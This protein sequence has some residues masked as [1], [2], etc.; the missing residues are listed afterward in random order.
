MM[1]ARFRRTWIPSHIDGARRI[2]RAPSFSS[3]NGVGPNVIGSRTAGY[4][5]PPD[6]PS[7][8]L[9]CEIA[10]PAIRSIMAREE[11]MQSASILEKRN[12][13]E[14]EASDGRA[15]GNGSQRLRRG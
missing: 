15:E 14:F 5:A 10:S 6:A 13:S 3:A 11:R 1:I 4:A 9:H 2:E 7:R 8:N 12:G